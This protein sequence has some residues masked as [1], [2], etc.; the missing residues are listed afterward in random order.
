LAFKPEKFNFGPIFAK[1]HDVTPYEKWENLS[2]NYIVE[3]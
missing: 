1:K 2:K 3:K